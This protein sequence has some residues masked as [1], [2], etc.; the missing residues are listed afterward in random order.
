M[1]TKSGGK[2]FWPTISLGD[3]VNSS[4]ISAWR[5]AVTAWLN[6][7][8]AGITNAGITW[9]LAIWSRKTQSTANVSIGQFSPLIGFQSNRR[10]PTGAV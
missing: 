6:A 3:I 9:T 2:I 10:K 7:V 8:K 5:T 4:P 1:G